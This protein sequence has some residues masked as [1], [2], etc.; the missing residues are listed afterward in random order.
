MFSAG[1]GVDRL[2][3]VLLEVAKNKTD[4]FPT[5]TQTKSPM[6]EDQENHPKF[7]TLIGGGTVLNVLK[8]QKEGT[9]L[10]TVIRHG[11]VSVNDY[12]SAGGWSG[13]V[14]RI[15]KDNIHSVQTVS[16]G[17][18]CKLMVRLTEESGEPT[19]L[20]DSVFFYASPTSLCE[21]TKKLVKGKSHEGIEV[22]E[23]QADRLRMEYSIGESSDG[24]F[25]VEMNRQILI[26]LSC[27]RSELCGAS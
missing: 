14:K 26:V 25:D 13:S 15:L 19:P 24:N 16:V 1:L 27:C 2:R 11:Q 9:A 23:E 4:C 12:F 10:H 20:G 5:E 21:Q 3:K 7:K 18:G 6:V 8:S 17:T 22:A